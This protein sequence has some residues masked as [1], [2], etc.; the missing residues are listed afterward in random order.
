MTK[1]THVQM[2]QV[3]IIESERGW[4]SKIDEVYHF[5]TEKEAR[6]W[7]EAYNKKYNNEPTV[8]DWYMSARYVGEC[9]V[10]PGKENRAGEIV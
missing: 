6:D 3:H 5:D 9:F 1:P 2:W 4:G 7:A 10:V 8:P